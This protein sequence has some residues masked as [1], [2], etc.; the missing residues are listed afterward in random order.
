MKSKYG[1]LFLFIL[2]LTLNA[3]AQFLRK[4]KKQAEQAAERTVLKKTD[5]IVT[6]KTEQTIDGV[7]E[8]DKDDNQDTEEREEVLVNQTSSQ[9]IPSSGGINPMMGGKKVD[10]SKLPNSYNF[11]WE[12]HTEIVTGNKET[13]TLTY[14]INTETTDYF[15]MEMATEQSK[16]QGD[17]KMVMDSKNQNTVMFMEGNGQK[18]AQVTNMPEVKPDKTDQNIKYTEIST[19]TILGYE[20]F[21]IQVE[22][23]QYIATMYYTLDAPITFS[24]LFGMMHSK[25][26]PKGFDPA[27][28]QVLAEESL[29]MEMTA[30]HK[31]KAKE[32]F[33]MAAKSLTK[34]STSI[35]TSDYQVMAFGGL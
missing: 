22:D 32:S 29:L 15:G 25:G 7:V 28:I 19:K 3:D 1:L 30:T 26:A 14:L 12:Y 9:G 5:E 31:K 33:T 23:P 10:T 6:K 11:N 4:L 16:K 27:L 24:S 34:K 8:G 13:I 17:I 18:M 21:G 35:K 2:G 20:C